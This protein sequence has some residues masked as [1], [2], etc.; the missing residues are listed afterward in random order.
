MPWKF[1]PF[2]GTLD[3]YESGT[4]GSI[5]DLSDVDT[6]TDTPELNEVLKWNGS[7]WVPA[8]Y[9]ATF[10]F[11]IASFTDNESATQLIG[12]GVWRAA[13]ALSFDMT[14]SNGPPTA[15]KIALSS[16]GGVSWTSDLTVSSPYTSASSAEDTSYPGAKDQYITF[17]LTADKG[18]ESDTDSE[19]VYFRNYIYWGVLTKNS[20][21]TEADVESL[22]NSAVSND[23]TRSMSLTASVG[24]YLVYAFPSSYTSIPHGSDY[25]TDGD[26]GFLFNS[27]AC[28]FKA[29]ETVSIT[30]S[31]GYTED[32]KVYGS[33][34][35]NLGSHTL[36]TTTS[37]AT[38]NPLYYGVT[39]KTSGY[40]EADIESL[41]NS[42]ITNDNTQEWDSVTTGSGEYMLF[43]FPKRLGLVTFWVGGFEGGFESPETVSVTNSNG[44]S[45]DY[46]AWRS[47]NANLGATVVTTT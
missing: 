7:E 47:T 43:A 46:Y 8:V 19:T 28:A 37:A 11:S 13:G 6:T 27:I 3:Y 24:E 4:A 10:S 29:P 40:T 39:T 32:Y 23:Q 1:N 15:A 22:A 38:I 36:V 5:D 18:A 42:E 12:S 30:N 44:W 9:N 41:A 26:T 33:E 14:Y 25:E 17:T 21:F 34:L 45:E 35:T 16:D 31:A 2:T 20:G